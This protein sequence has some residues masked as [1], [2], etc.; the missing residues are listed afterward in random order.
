MMDIRDG[1]D[2]LNRK[3]DRKHLGMRPPENQV[4]RREYSL[5]HYSPYKLWICQRGWRKHDSVQNLC[6][7]DPGTIPIENPY[8][9][10]TKSL[11]KYA[12]ERYRTKYAKIYAP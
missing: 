6:V 1:A 3:H 9:T 8:T 10:T 5:N 12:N 2:D 11:A 7:Y 4:H